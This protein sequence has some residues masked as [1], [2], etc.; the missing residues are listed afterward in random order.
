MFQIGVIWLKYYSMQRYFEILKL[1]TAN[2]TISLSDPI[3]GSL[4]DARE[5]EW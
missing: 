5:S 2:Q 4:V 1:F 3:S